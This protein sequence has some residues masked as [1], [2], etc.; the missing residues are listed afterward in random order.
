MKSQDK[1]ST[2]QGKS[3][4]IVFVPGPALQALHASAFGLVSEIHF[5]IQLNPTF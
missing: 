2:F 1:L 5:I 4:P 3:N